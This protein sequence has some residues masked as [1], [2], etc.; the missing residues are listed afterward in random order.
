MSSS[1]TYFIKS[2][3]LKKKERAITMRAVPISANPLKLDVGSHR[4]CLLI[5]FFLTMGTFQYGGFC[6]ICLNP[7][8]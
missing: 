7:A 8:E 2:F 4:K 6:M 1:T 3:D 5:C